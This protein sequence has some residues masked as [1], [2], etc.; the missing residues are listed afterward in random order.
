V[1]GNRG[2]QP[3]AHA[4]HSPRDLIPIRSSIT[5]R[6]VVSCGE[7]LGDV[8]V[9]GVERCQ[10]FDMPDPVSITTEHRSVRRR[11]SC[12]K[13][14]PGIRSTGGCPSDQLRPERQG[15]RPLPSTSSPTNPTPTCSPLLPGVRMSPTKEACL[16]TFDG[17][18]VVH[19]AWPCTSRTTRPPM[20]SA[21][22]ICSEI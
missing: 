2:K 15:R 5:S 20:R 18:M 6:F 9:E 12:G 11:C 4:R 14:S 10:A 3:G 8:P 1:E 22:V 21:V 19:A 17:G 7:D 13:L 16:G